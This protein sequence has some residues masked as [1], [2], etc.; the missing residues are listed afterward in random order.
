MY[1]TY[2]YFWTRKLFNFNFDSMRQRA[3][4]R[5]TKAD[6]TANGNAPPRSSVDL[7]GTDFL[8]R[9]EGEIQDQ[10]K[11]ALDDQTKTLVHYR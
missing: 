2:L 7:T 10:D 4:I 5:C 11:L 1:H 9:D 8:P 3:K 6:T